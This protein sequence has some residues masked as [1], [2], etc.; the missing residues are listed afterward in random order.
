MT[1]LK[2][3]KT[4]IAGIDSTDTEALNKILEAKF[5][6]LLLPPVESYDFV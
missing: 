4:D 1:K 3:H 5:R 2:K 6:P